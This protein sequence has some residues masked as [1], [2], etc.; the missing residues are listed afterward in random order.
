MGN[1]RRTVAAVIAGVMS[2][3]QAVPSAWAWTQAEMLRQGPTLPTN[4]D[5]AIGRLVLDESGSG[6][7]YTAKELQ[8][9]G[10]IRITPDVLKS[11]YR[12]LIEM[13]SYFQQA[14][15]EFEVSVEE[16]LRVAEP[17]FAWH[18]PEA[19]TLD[20]AQKSLLL[21]MRD[22]RDPARLKEFI[23]DEGVRAAVAALPFSR[24]W[25][26]VI[27]HGSDRAALDEQILQQLSASSGSRLP[28]PTRAG[29]GRAQGSGQLLPL[30]PPPAPVAAKRRAVP[31]SAFEALLDIYDTIH[32]GAD[33]TI[34]LTT[35]YLREIRNINIEPHKPYNDTTLRRERRILKRVGL[36]NDKLVLHPAVGG[37]PEEEFDKFLEKLQHVAPQLQQGSLSD[38]EIADVHAAIAPLLASLSAPATPAAPAAAPTSYKFFGRPLV[39]PASRLEPGESG[40]D[41]V[42]GFAAGVMEV[43]FD[44]RYGHV[45][46]SVLANQLGRA[47]DTLKPDLFLLEDGGAVLIERRAVAVED[48]LIQ[49]HVS[50]KYEKPLLKF[51]RTIT[52][53]RVTAARRKEL[54]PQIAA[55]LAGRSPGEVTPPPQRA[56]VVPTDVKLQAALAALLTRLQDDDSAA[57][58]IP[59]PAAAP[60]LV[61]PAVTPAPSAPTR[62]GINGAGRIGVNL[63]RGWLQNPRAIA[64]VGLNDVAFDFKKNGGA[65]LKNYVELLKAEFAS[66]PRSTVQAAAF[67]YGKDEAGYW[68]SI[69]GQRITVT[70]LPDPSKLPWS[71]LK[72]D[73]VLE[74]TGRFT[75]QEDAAKH[76]EAG[77]KRVIITAPATGD[78]QTIVPGVN[79]DAI[80]GASAVTSCAS[81]TTNAIAPPLRVLVDALGI[82]EFYMSTTH[83]YTADQALVETLRPA[84]PLRGRAAPINIIPT[85]TGAASAIGE[86]IPELRGKGSGI[87]VRVPVPNGSL[88]GITM[89]VSKRTTREGVNRLLKEAAQGRLNGIMDY[90]DEQLVSR[91]ILGRSAS[92]IIDGKLTYVSASGKLVTIWVWYDNEFGY[93]NRVLD[94]VNLIHPPVVTP[95]ATAPA[96]IPDEIAQTVTEQLP[97]VTAAIAA[98]TASAVTPTILDPAIRAHLR[99]IIAAMVTPVSGILA[100][101]ESV[102]TAEKRLKSVGLE[103]TPENRQAMRQM[104]LMAPG[105]YEAGI[106]AVILD[107]DTLTNTTPDGTQTIPA[108]LLAHGIVPGL[109]TDAGIDTDPAFPKETGHKLPKPDSLAKLPVLLDKA[110]ELDL[111][112]TKWRITIPAVNPD[113]A[114]MR[115]NAQMLAKQAKLTQEA[116]LVPIVEPEVIFDGSDGT[117]ATHSL[118]ASK[119]ATTRMLQITFEE[120]AKEGVWLPGVILKTS[121]V[122]AGKNAP[123]Q[124]LADLIGQETINVLLATV[125]AEV[126][127]IVFLS[128]GQGDVQATENL[129]AVARAAQAHGNVPWPI[130]YSFGRGLQAKALKAWG[131]KLEN[132]AAAQAAMVANARDVQAARQGRLKTSRAAPPATALSLPE[133]LVPALKHHGLTAVKAEAIP[134]QAQAVPPNL[135]A[136]RFN[137][138]GLSGSIAQA[139]GSF[140]FAGL[141][142]EAKEIADGNAV[143]FAETSIQYFT[144]QHADVAVVVL[145]DEG[146]RD[147]SFSLQLGSVYVGGTKIAYSGMAGLLAKLDELRAQGKTILYFVGDAL[148][149]TNGLV[150]PEAATQATDSNAVFS[151]YIETPETRLGGEHQFLNDD[152]NRIGG[153]S[154]VAPDD[155]GVTP[156]DLPSEAL[157]KIA[158][159]NARAQRLT[160]GTPDFNRFDADYTFNRLVTDYIN[161]TVV[162]AL[163]PR[164]STDM[165]AYETAVSTHRHQA[166]INDT[167][168]LQVKYPGL[169]VVF[170]GDG[171][172][173]PRVV[174]TLGI[175]LDSKHMVVFGRSGSTEARA[176]MIAVLNSPNARFVHSYAS[177]AT[178]GNYSRQTAYEYTAAERQR[179]QETGVPESVY[180]TS[181]STADIQGT[182]VLALTSV[183][184]ASEAQYSPSFAAKYQ[185][186]TVQ[187]N[188]GSSGTITTSTILSTRQGNFLVRTVLESKDIAGSINSVKNGIH[189]ARDYWRRQ[190]PPQVDALLA[191]LHQ[192]VPQL[193]AE[194]VQAELHSILTRRAQGALTHLEAMAQI[195]ALLHHADSNLAHA[196]WGDVITAIDAILH[197]SASAPTAAATATPGF[198]PE[199]QRALVEAERQPDI[200]ASE[201][202]VPTGPIPAL[203]SA[204]APADAPTQ[205]PTYAALNA[206]ERAIVDPAVAFVRERASSAGLGGSEE[207]FTRAW[208]RI[209]ETLAQAFKGQFQ[210]RQDAIN[211]LKGELQFLSIRGLDQLQI[212][213]TAITMVAP[214]LLMAQSGE[215]GKV[216]EK[217]RLTDAQIEEWVN[218]WIRTH[219]ADSTQPVVRVSLV[220]AR[221]GRHVSVD[222]DPDNH[223]VWITSHTE[224][225]ADEIISTLRRISHVPPSVVPPVVPLAFHALAERY[226]P[227]LLAPH[228]P[229]PELLRAA[230][231]SYQELSEPRRVWVDHEAHRAMIREGRRAANQQ[232]QDALDSEKTKR[233]LAY[234]NAHG[235]EHDGLEQAMQLL[236]DAG[237]AQARALE[238]YH[239]VIAMRFMAESLPGESSPQPSSAAP[240]VEVPRMVAIGSGEAIAKLTTKGTDIVVKVEKG[241]NPAVAIATAVA[242]LAADGVDAL[243]EIGRGPNPPPLLK[244]PDVYLDLSAAMVVITPEESTSV[245]SQAIEVAYRKVVDSS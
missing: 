199:V 94:L 147:D 21:F 22:I 61:T 93:A 139:L 225:T 221:P 241:G 157:P 174:A 180:G 3:S 145:A 146:A 232:E 36:V 126:G 237:H 55:I 172:F 141:G 73:V 230:E 84:A 109:K 233:A 64:I 39:P 75:K 14:A 46:L 102:G 27:L 243:S 189:A 208:G 242:A 68:I 220:R 13:Q 173:G 48:W 17:R 171:D 92:S 2:L 131:G 107:R 178:N 98:E 185:R 192:A 90:S 41:T 210:T 100:A 29:A 179:F 197:E 213:Q 8:V 54:A 124:T 162:V 158:A 166:I 37:L 203:H 53:S 182:G 217:P 23:P 81:C 89:V 31:G 235:R 154:F 25:F 201:L 136:D 96:A 6:H 7:F 236:R 20:E 111:G 32:F 91:D 97:A 108:Y 79:E 66:A 181:R 219:P 34:P 196:E 114:N 57:L 95:R 69:N 99:E 11:D 105:L 134:L 223:T 159:S 65:G 186:V 38:E 10:L 83:A 101:D 169:K 51:L 30:T 128:G 188:A 202:N 234:A 184:G 211:A 24:D 142:K 15:D 165:K 86:A 119:A 49:D 59:P 205:A 138:F 152:N 78:L 26:P 151:F 18:D 244:R 56:P 206:T 148:E 132:I 143:F 122:L 200:A 238:L 110:V 231:H 103:N 209:P 239:K 229:S 214:K 187:K 168:A 195:N 160:K 60:A 228:G 175:D 123:A 212:A 35:H 137:T 245:K 50:P 85:T 222:N 176:T 164:P 120:L 140:F 193:A 16:A 127:A 70:D 153:V 149:K 215:G 177:Q 117:S 42:P 194:A 112:F 44:S 155:A 204:E 183:T 47:A 163:G 58:A 45:N 130:S 88:V 80:A 104:L 224:T 156:F 161:S 198:R 118:E 167:K 150:V 106:T 121:M 28:G 9:Q 133:D 19:N 82:E 116:G 115:A 76:L 63:I 190:E 170:P 4:I 62:V 191:R 216:A 227:H 52:P 218:A 87:A 1:L 226:A 72:V 12:T 207:G 113:E 74:A 43:L 125:P 5:E 77:A 144:E 240:A 67:D 33:P 71:A 129:D 135:L 40:P